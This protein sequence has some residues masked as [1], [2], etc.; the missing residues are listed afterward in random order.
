MKKSAQCN[1]SERT[2]GNLKASLLIRRN[3]KNFPVWTQSAILSGNTAANSL[4][5]VFYHAHRHIWASFLFPLV[6]LSYVILWP[7][8]SPQMHCSGLAWHPEVATQMVLASEDDRLPVIQMWDLRFASSPLRVLESHTRYESYIVW[9]A[10]WYLHCW[11]LL[12]FVRLTSAVPWGEGLPWCCQSQ[13][14]PCCML[15]CWPASPVPWKTSVFGAWY[16]EG[17]RPQN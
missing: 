1:L 15:A 17:N 2:L 7:D 16:S 8:V 10:P 11:F 13:Q 9:C 14:Q 3:K 5:E 12:Q 6:L 4:G